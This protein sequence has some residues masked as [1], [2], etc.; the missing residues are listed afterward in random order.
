MTRIRPP[1]GIYG[2]KYFQAPWIISYFPE[3]YE[4]M[5]YV[6]PYGGAANV[7]LTKLPS[8]VEVYNDLD[9]L[10]INF[11]NVLRNDFEELQRRL[12]VTP[13]H[14]GEWRKCKGLVNS[15]D[16][17]IKAISF[18]VVS[19]QSVGYSGTGFGYV[20]KASSSRLPPIIS[21]WLS[22]IDKNLSLVVGR[23]RGVQFM[24]RPALKVI[25]LFDSLNTLFYLD[26]PYVADTRVSKRNYQHEMSDEDHQE[27]L[28]LLAQ[29]KGR[30]ILS[31]YMNRLYDSHA[32]QFGWLCYERG[33]QNRLASHREF[34]DE[35]IECLWTNINSVQYQY[36]QLYNRLLAENAYLNLLIRLENELE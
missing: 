25:Q 13:Y 21:A 19:R 4:E 8:K 35:L 20:K 3:G 7:L 10:I 15:K 12:S 27:L 17:M 18:F 31:G 24:Q 11:F 5:V 29:I 9:D 6:E 1:F 33:F 22:S 16:P 26:P 28:D 2:S 34:E 14:E 32:K 23:L 36:Q 30:F